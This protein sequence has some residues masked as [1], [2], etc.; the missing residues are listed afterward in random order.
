[1]SDPTPLPIPEV[2]AEVLARIMARVEFEPNTG[3]WLWAGALTSAG[4]GNAYL[5][6]GYRLVHRVMYRSAGHIQGDEVLDHKC[7]TRACVNP[8]HLRP[9]SRGENVL[10]PGSLAPT[11]LNLLKTHCARGHPYD[12]ANTRRIIK[13]GRPARICI[14]CSR[15]DSNDYYERVR[16]VRR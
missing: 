14:A 12:E 2:P 7:H 13:K 11:A 3:C 9:M 4:Y 6:G 15:E 5:L 1:M 10:A 8:D 16:K